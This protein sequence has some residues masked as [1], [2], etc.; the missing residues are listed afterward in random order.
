M[1][2]KSKALTPGGP[3]AAKPLITTLDGE[4]ITTLPTLHLHL[5]AR[6]L[7]LA[8]QTPMHNVG[9]IMPQLRRNLAFDQ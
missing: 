8:G 7:S 5:I 3:G 9:A 2:V 6:K 1:L 4:S